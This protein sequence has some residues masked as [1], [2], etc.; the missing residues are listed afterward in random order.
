MTL[1]HIGWRRLLALTLGV[2]VVAGISGFGASATAA[3]RQLATKCVGSNDTDVP[4]PDAGAAVSSSFTIAGCGRAAS[5]TS[6]LALHIEHTYR[7]DL[8][9]T[10]VAPDGST[11]PL[12]AAA[13]Y[14]SGDNYDYNG[15]INLSS[16][17]AD[18]T[19]QLRVQDIYAGNTGYV[20]TFTL[21][22]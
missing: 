13:D 18:G 12:K 8:V 1:S 3:P 14:D 16:E 22:I 10:L 17:T 20:D 19:W 4:I 7:G 21:T 5:S 15:T 9:V 6:T 11:Y 2:T